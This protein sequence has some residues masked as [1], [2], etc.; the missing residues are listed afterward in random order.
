MNAR[1]E[2]L[3]R[4]KLVGYRT[5]SRLGQLGTEELGI[6]TVCQAVSSLLCAVH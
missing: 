6:R 2:N 3:H 4:G 1:I 5:L